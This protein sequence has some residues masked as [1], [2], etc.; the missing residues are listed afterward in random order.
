ML[1]K[2]FNNLPSKT[3]WERVGS[4]KRFG[5]YV[6]LFSLRSRHDCGIGDIGDLFYLVDFCREIGAAIIQLL[7]LNDMG[8]D[9]NPYLA[10]SAFA[11]DPLFIDLQ[12][13][14]E[15]KSDRKLL[16]K[17]GEI[18][19]RLNSHHRVNYAEVRR[20]KHG[21]LHEAFK[22][23]NRKKIR[24]EIEDF[25]YRNPWLERYVLFRIIREIEEFRSWEQWAQ[26]YADMK[27]IED[28]S[29]DQKDLVDF[30][31]YLQVILET[32]MSEARNYAGRNGVLIEGDIPILVARDSA[33]VWNNPEF[34]KLD[35]AAGAPP[36]MYA[37]DGQ[38]WGAPTYN[39]ENLMQADYSFW[40]N[41][42]KHAEKFYDMYRIDHVV[43]F[44]RIW[45]IRYGEKTARNGWYVPWNEWEWGNH[46]R[47]LLMMMLQSSGM[48]PLAEDL[49]TIPP[50]CRSTL[51]DLG[52][53]GLKVQRWEKRWNGDGS[54]IPPAEYD[55]LS[56][57]TLSTHDSELLPE[58]WEKYPA[59]RDQLWRTLGH[60]GNAPQNLSM[61]MNREIISYI[62]SVR[63]IFVILMLQEILFPFGM[64]PGHPSDHRINIPGIVNEKN[65]TWRC[66]AAI[67][68]MNE[69]KELIEGMREMTRI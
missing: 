21:I 23:M 24:S 12:R 16:E 68:D 30:Y 50:V 9:C 56:V 60:E 42:L 33:D 29:K 55:N 26:K 37:E 7:P 20:E 63:S 31:S 14:E 53:C 10:I 18:S 15:I 35:T 62:C 34:F 38:N 8:S 17:A 11:L 13:I 25:S 52:I 43:G 1:P 5:I 3:H 66:P 22:K 49:G 58:W 57:A 59:E 64:L 4:E 36:D 39:W 67:E 44:F 46:G 19:G 6:P 51:K 45:T 47:E 69:N 40:R 28:L 2:Y 65:W 48:L 54:F 32:Q 27:I 61:D 41:R